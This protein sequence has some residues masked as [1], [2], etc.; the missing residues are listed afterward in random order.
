MKEEVSMKRFSSLLIVAILLLSFDTAFGCS[1]SSPW[2]DTPND[3]EEQFRSKVEGALKYTDFVFAAEVV[4]F[5]KPDLSVLHTNN[6]NPFAEL[7]KL[8]IKFKVEQIWKGEDTEEIIMRAVAGTFS[9]GH[10]WNA[11]GC[12]YYFEQG[13]KY[14]IY[15]DG[16]KD[17]LSVHLC[18]RTKLLEAAEREVEILHS[19]K[20]KEEK[21]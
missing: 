16:S 12:G 5:K 15:A 7:I 3:T 6:K 19:L 2:Q 1:C 13:K 10:K 20:R 18:S 11:V 4:E 8:K 14:L 21:P 17:K 9:N